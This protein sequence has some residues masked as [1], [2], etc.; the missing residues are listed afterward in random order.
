MDFLISKLE[1]DVEYLYS[2]G[3]RVD[4]I[5]MNPEVYE[6]FITLKQG[7][8]TIDIPIEADGNVEKYEFIYSVI[9]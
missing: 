4:K 5:K 9:Q 1:E 7:A 2:Q 8:S 3:K 6:H